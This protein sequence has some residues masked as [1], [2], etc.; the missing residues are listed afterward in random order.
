MFSFGEEHLSSR[1][2]SKNL[3]I[4]RT[5]ILLV[6]VVSVE[7]KAEIGTGNTGQVPVQTDT[8]PGV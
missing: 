6:F 2:L 7:T 1:F 8:S 4:Y 5:I 3:K